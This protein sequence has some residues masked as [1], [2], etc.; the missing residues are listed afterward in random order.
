MLPPGLGP[1]SSADFGD[2]DQDGDIDLSRREIRER[3]PDA[4]AFCK[5]K[6]ET[7]T[8]GSMSASTSGRRMRK[9]PTR[10][11]SHRPGSGIDSLPEDPSRL[12]DPMVQKPVTHFGIGSLDA[13]DV[14]RVLW[15]TGVPVNVLNPAK[16]KTVIQ[17][18][19]GPAK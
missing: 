14:L 9:P 10:T 5:T 2:L 6:A 11:A 1:I 12:A 17:T 18:P 8:T 3:V 7:R 15:N 19:P 4:W 13:A 16:N